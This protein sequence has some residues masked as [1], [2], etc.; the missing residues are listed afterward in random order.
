[1]VG[2]GKSDHEAVRAVLDGDKEA[3]GALVVRHSHSLFRVAFRITGNE[4]DADDVVQ[5]AFLR[6]YRKLESF[7]SRASFG[8]WI[9]RIAVRCALDR[10]K[11]SKGNDRSRVAEETDP[12]LDDVQVPDGGGRPG[13]AT[14]E[15]RNWRHA[16][17]RDAGPVANGADGV[18]FAPRGGLLDGRD[19]RGAGDC[20]ECGQASGVS[21]RAQAAVALIG[22]QGEDMKHL[23]EEELVAQ[24][25][26]E[27]EARRGEAVEAHL[28]ECAECADSY[29]VLLSDLAAMK[30]MTTPERDE[31]YG[32]RVWQSV[33]GSLAAY[34]QNKRSWWLREW[35]GAAWLK[36]LSY[37][38]VCA[39]LVVG[40][41]FA[42][43]QWE[44]WKQQPPTATVE[45]KS[46]QAKQPI[47]VVVLDEH[48]DR[49]ERFLVELKHADLDSP[50][51]ATP[52]R[53]EARSRW[54]RTR[55]AGKRPRRPAT[56][57]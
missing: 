17:G 9:Y 45:H 41:F 47:V 12:E 52:I 8:T 7:E 29:L 53:D 56:R 1:M 55:Y 33:E 4:A 26:G 49:S 57:I 16:G 23:S 5:E 21:C 15:R 35:A 30:R 14:A 24:A 36:G 54:R 19:C 20:A 46:P 50:A 37:A 44:R 38:A 18:C 3:Y 51:M 34:E 40:A 22:I 42:G 13:A 48:L 25:L 43:R 39:L 2:M 31:W 27:R 11:S 6:G 32:E 28:A 10:L